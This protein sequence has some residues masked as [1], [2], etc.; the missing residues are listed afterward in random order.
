[1][2]FWDSSAIAPL[3]LAE[4]RSFVV[5]QLHAIDET[6]VAAAITP[7]E[8]ASVL[9]RR[10]HAGKLTLSAHGL[11][12]RLFAVVSQSWLEIAYT[13]EI[14]DIARDLLGRHALRSLDALQLASAISVAGNAR[15]LPFVTLDEKLALAAR[16]EGFVVLP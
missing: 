8:V 12:E 9:W 1:L 13:P 6:V 14:T 15:S 5:R 2:R 7:L 10:R 4:P 16:S 11:A 3:L